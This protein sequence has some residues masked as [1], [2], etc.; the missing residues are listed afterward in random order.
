MSFLIDLLALVFTQRMRSLYS[1]FLAL[2]ATQPV[3]MRHRGHQVD[4][5][6]VDGGYHGA[7]DWVCLRRVFI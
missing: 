6:I 1:L 5:H 3:F 2:T 7:G 4:K